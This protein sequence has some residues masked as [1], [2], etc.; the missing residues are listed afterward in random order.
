[1]MEAIFTVTGTR[2]LEKGLKIFGDFLKLTTGE[3]GSEKHWYG[4]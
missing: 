3:K 2:S 4:L 1:M